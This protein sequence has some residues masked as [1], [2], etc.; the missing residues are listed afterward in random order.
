MSRAMRRAMSR[1]MSRTY[2]SKTT[3][4][5][6]SPPASADAL[7]P[8]DAAAWCPDRIRYPRKLI[9]MKVWDENSGGTDFMDGPSIPPDSVVECQ[10][11]P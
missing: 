7:I 6:S 10:I 1:A 9:G 8:G 2:R 11:N 5:N 4:P 3:V